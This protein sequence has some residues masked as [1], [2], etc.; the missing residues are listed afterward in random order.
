MKY[1]FLIMDRVVVSPISKSD[2]SGQNGRVLAVFPGYPEGDERA[3]KYPIHLG[4]WYAIAFEG[5]GGKDP[6]FYREAWLRAQIQK[7]QISGPFTPLPPM[8]PATKT[9]GGWFRR[10]RA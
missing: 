8:P 5:D 4:P 1:K 10:P 6:R 7:D 3:K 9:K 2:R